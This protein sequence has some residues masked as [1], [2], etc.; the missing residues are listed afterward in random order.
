MR[1]MVEGHA[2]VFLTPMPNAILR[3]PLPQLR[4][5]PSPKGEEQKIQKPL[6]RRPAPKP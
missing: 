2:Q 1:S 4:W 3:V 5:S 6:G